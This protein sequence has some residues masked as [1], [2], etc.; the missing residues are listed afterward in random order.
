[1]HGAFDEDGIVCAIH[2]ARGMVVRHGLSLEGRDGGGLEDFRFVAQ[3]VHEAVPLRADFGR[4]VLLHA[5]AA[6]GDAVAHKESL[7][8]LCHVGREPRPVVGFQ[9]ASPP[10]NGHKKSRYAQ[11]NGL[12]RFFVHSGCDGNSVFE[13]MRKIWV[14]FQVF[15]IPIFAIPA[16]NQIMQ[17]FVGKVL[18]LVCHL[19]HPYSVQHTSRYRIVPGCQHASPIVRSWRS[20]IASMFPQDFSACSSAGRCK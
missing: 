18:I 5:G 9:G 20:C 8:G 7:G 19:N 1:M 4:K 2:L 13:L 3:D 15:E 10:K 6:D 11:H 12:C 16:F 17:F 14:F